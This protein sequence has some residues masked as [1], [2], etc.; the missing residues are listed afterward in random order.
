MPSGSSREYKLTFYAYKEGTTLAEV[1]FKNEQTQEYIP[2]ELSFKS[3]PAGVLDS[4][5]VKTTVRHPVT[6]SV[7]LANPLPT[8]VHFTQTCF[9]LE[10]GG[11][12]VACNE[13]H[14]PTSFR[15]PSRTESTEYAFEFLPLRPRDGLAR[16]TLA[17][18]ELGSFHFDLVLSAASVPPQPEETFR[19]SLGETVTKKLK[20]TNFCTSRCEF[21]STIDGGQQQFSCGPSMV[22]PAS[23]KSGTDLYLD[24]TFDP[25]TLG[26]SKATLTISSPVG[27]DFVFPLFGACAPPKASGPHTV[28]AGAGAR[29]TLPFKNVF[30]TIETYSYSFDN[31]AFSVA[32]VTELYKSKETKDVLVKYDSSKDASNLSRLTVTCASAPGIE[33]IFYLK[34]EV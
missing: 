21:L 15:V 3:T 18:P 19:T 24:V 13:I 8:P 34:G 16:L 31:P 28:K 14:G 30:N 20:F 1:V 11:G 29:F 4:L 17:C 6:A 33:W 23:V 7:T 26:D 9:Y 2:Y 25:C 27:G 10:N 12:K 5:S 22:A 32:K